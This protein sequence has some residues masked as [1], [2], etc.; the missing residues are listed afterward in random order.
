LRFIKA[1]ALYP[2]GAYLDDASLA[3]APQAKMPWLYAIEKKAGPEAPS[4][5]I[6][7][8]SASLG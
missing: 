8:T 1:P 4:S 6:S 2:A 3:K 5:S 7:K